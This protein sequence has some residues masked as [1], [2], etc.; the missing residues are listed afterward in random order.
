MST[1]AL[2]RVTITYCTQC[3]WLL[4]AAWMAQELLSTFGADLGEV[5]LIPGTGGIFQ[6]HCDGVQVWDR[7]TQGGFPDAKTLKQAVR[8]RIDPGR[9]L[10][11]AERT[12]D[13]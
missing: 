4:R 10:G 2:P 9:D 6:V 1:P 5:A 8:D 13:T 11:H 12:R 7:K 3:Q